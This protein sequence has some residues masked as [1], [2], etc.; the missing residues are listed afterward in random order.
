MKPNSREQRPSTRLF[1]VRT[2][3]LTPTLTTA[4]TQ[5]Q[6]AKVKMNTH[7]PAALMKADIAGTERTP[8]RNR[9]DALF[10]FLVTDAC[11]KLL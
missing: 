3:L 11:Q 9:V 4:M 5:T 1:N 2:A 6:T 10:S 8:V 7:P